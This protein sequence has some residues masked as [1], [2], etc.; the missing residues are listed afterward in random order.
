MVFYIYCKESYAMRDFKNI[1][2]YPS[3]VISYYNID[4]NTCRGS[5]DTNLEKL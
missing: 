2:V 5:F 4:Y 1:N 3:P